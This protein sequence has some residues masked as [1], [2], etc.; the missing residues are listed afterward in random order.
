MEFDDNFTW[1]EDSGT[2][3]IA[4]DYTWFEYPFILEEQDGKEEI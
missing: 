1:T 3:D 4:F 2:N